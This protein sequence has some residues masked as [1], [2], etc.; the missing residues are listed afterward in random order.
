MISF[1]ISAIVFNDDPTHEE[2]KDDLHT[3]LKIQ[4]AIVF[5][6]FVFFQ[7][8]FREKPENPPSQASL[9][10][11]E[12]KSPLIALKEI[13]MNKSLLALTVTFSLMIGLL[14]SLG[15]TMSPLFSPFGFQ[16]TGVACIG[17]IMLISGII[18]STV[19]GAVL[20][21]TAAYKRLIQ[22]S[23]L[24]FT[25]SLSLL[26]VSLLRDHSHVL[27]Y[28]YLVPFG[29]SLVSIMPS[30]LGLG[31]ELTFTKLEPAIVNGMMMFCA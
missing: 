20:D 28:L 14:F 10:P 27:T 4:T 23:I 17:L 21:K 13:S 18:G 19:T 25:V 3:V 1:G 7:L 2:F 29:F 12:I 6:A 11:V 24:I 9:A 31:V 30:G 8:M 22:I 16:P 15:N 5:S 26:S